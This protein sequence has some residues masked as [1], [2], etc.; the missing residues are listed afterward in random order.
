LGSSESLAEPC[1]TMDLELDHTTRTLLEGYGFDRELFAQLRARFLAGELSAAANRLRGRVEPPAKSDIHTL[2]PRGSETRETLAQ[3]GAAALRA[4]EVGCV[5]LAGGMATRFGGVVK[6]GVEALAGRS[7]LSLKIADIRRVARQAGGQVPVCLMSSFATHEV[8]LELA[9]REQSEEAPIE[10]FPQLISLRMSPDGSLFQEDG[11]PSPYAPGHGDLTFALRRAGTLARFLGRGGRV[12]AT[13]NVDNL[14][15]TLDA[16]I[17]GAHLQ[18][19]VAMTVE[20]GVR[21]PGELGGAPARVDGRLQIV[22]DFR[23]PPGFELGSIPY[24]NTNTFVLDARALDR[25]FALTWFLVRK[26]VGGRETIQFEHLVG[27]LSAFLSCACLEVPRDGEDG[28]FQPAKDPEELERRKPQIERILR[29]R[30][31]L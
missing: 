5:V 24:F 18:A 23:F 2:P 6:A 27:E 1:A 26:R 17:I 7:F 21:T 20:V 16:A 9:A 12:L 3:R 28:R 14:G 30:G 4:G 19:E 10:V 8:L 29:A 31:I 11:R 25:D 15:A 13:S 22:E